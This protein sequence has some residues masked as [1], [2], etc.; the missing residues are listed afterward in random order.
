MRAIWADAAVGLVGS[1]KIMGRKCIGGFLLGRRDGG[2][3]EWREGK[4]FFSRRKMERG[5]S[6]RGSQKVSE[7][8]KLANFGNWNLSPPE[9]KSLVE[10]GLFR[11]EEWGMVLQSK[12]VPPA[13]RVWYRKR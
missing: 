10:F 13:R 11:L 12:I 1:K 7:S 2:G 5:A 9:T 3:G 8:R 4:E 6:Y